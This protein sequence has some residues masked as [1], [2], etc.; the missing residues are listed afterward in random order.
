MRAFAG[1]AL[2]ATV[3]ALVPGRAEAAPPA[4]VGRSS[5]PELLDA[6][7]RRGEIDRVSADL[8]LS[9]AFAGRDRASKI[10]ARFRSDVPWDGTLPLL[11][12]QQRLRTQPDGPTK[13]RIEATLAAATSC[14]DQGATL[15]NETTSTHF[16]VTYGTIS[17]GLTVTSYVNSLEAAWST[18]VTSYGWAAPPSLAS[19][20]PPP[21]GSKYVVRID[22][23]GP[24]L[25]GFVSTEGTGAGFVG[26]NPNTGWSDGD[27]YASCMSL[28]NDFSGFPGTS[29]QALDATTAHE[30]NHSIQFGYGAISGFNVPDDLF[31]EGGATW[32]EDEVFDGANDNYN[33]LWPDFT[34][35]LG[36]YDGSPYETWIMLR[37]LTERFGTGNSGGGEQVM[38]D[39]WEA[40]SQGTGNNLSALEIGLANK[41]VQLRD[42]YHDF[43]VAAGFMR[44]CGASY[45]LPYCFEEA[46]GYIAGAGGLPPV[47]GSI[48]SVG[49]S[50]P[51]SIEDDYALS[52]VSLPTSGSYSVTLANTSAGG[53]LRGTAVC[54]NGTSLVRQPLPAVVGASASTTLTTFNAGGCVRVLAVVTNQQQSVGNPS[55]SLSRSFTLS[56]GATGPNVP[57]V[58]NDDSYSTFEGTPLTIAAPGVLANDTDV[59]GN[60]L[61]ATLPTAQVGGT[62]SLNTNGSFTFTPTP[63]FTGSGGFSY[64]AND[65]QGGTDPATVT[66]TVN[67]RPTYVPLTPARLLDTRSGAT[68]I[69]GISAGGGAVGPNA[70]R[71]LQ[72]TGRGGVPATPVGAVALNIT[73]VGSTT[74]GFLTVFPTGETRP[75]ASNLNFGPGT[76]I[77]NLVIAKVGTGGQVSIYNNAGS[78]HIVADVAGWYPS[79]TAKSYAPVTPARLMD[80]RTGATTVDGVSAGGG[81]VGPNATRSLQVTGRGGVPASGV[82][83][84][85]LNITAV[86]PTASGFLTVFPTGETRPLASNLNF[87]TNQTIPNLVISKIGTGGQV[88]IYNAI[89][90]S[91]VIADVA[92]WFPTTSDYSALSPARLMDTRPGTSTVDGVS[93]GTGAIGPGATRTLTVTGRGG[94][95]SG[96]GVGAVVL[97]ITAVGSTTGGFFTVFPTGEARPLASNLNFG[98]G[99]IIANLVIA[100]VGAGGQVSIYN[101]SGSTH[102]VADVAGWLPAV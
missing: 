97:N 61:T 91:H 90:S 50:F 51:S 52:W 22:N 54:D 39:F 34:E 92:G 40:T 64:T 31:F 7:V 99:A 35:S 95:P 38:Q 77:P 84:V 83:A 69:D 58:A 13:A 81:V 18:E 9:E 49:G 47:A 88:S 75:L 101:D 30:F 89:G 62:V 96:G 82:A 63:G 33:Y 46:A 1:M 59:N 43:A 66:I 20:P 19:P 86:T 12:L 72:V 85:V 37:G 57:P 23:L 55:A 29:Q 3:L 79:G 21:I 27:A 6:A 32:M 11:R 76:T 42:A 70:T 65:G 73:A 78:T 28:N 41:G 17:G 26:N 4:G 56:I 93:A 98:P 67:A 8:H 53:Q 44:T 48:A 24:G 14:S 15:A 36:D 94:V 68:T 71:T 45:V 2:L 16:Y 100:K 5:T 25:Y 10:P 74:G 60:L 87:T 102:V 80:T